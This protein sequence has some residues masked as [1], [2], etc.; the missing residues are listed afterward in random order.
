MIESLCMLTEGSF[1]YGNRE[2]KKEI[3]GRETI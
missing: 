1:D 2:M 3:R